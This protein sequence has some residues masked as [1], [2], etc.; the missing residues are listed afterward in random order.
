MTKQYS[1]ARSARLRLLLPASL[2][3]ALMVLPAK[4]TV[5][6]LLDVEKLAPL[7]S[8][9]FYGQVDS[10]ETYWNAERTRIYTR[11]RVHIEETF[12][13]SVG[14]SQIVTVTQ[15]GGEID[16]AKLDY[17]GRPDFSVGE[18]VVLFT[19]RGKNND[20]IVVGLKQGKM[21]VQG[22]EVK[23]DFSGITLV[24]RSTGGRGL[25][26]LT[27]RSERMTIDELRDRI[28]RARQ[29]R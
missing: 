20:F 19:T 24:Q 16:G 22:R 4:A 25:Q 8:D 23:R 10:T 7:S 9:I 3:A 17:A 11:I 21:T 6:E 12:K 2:L 28:A 18:K 29:A 27:I 13:G 26:Q 5:M 15:L 1:L 14:I